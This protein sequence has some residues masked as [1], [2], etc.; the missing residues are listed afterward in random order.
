MIKTGM[1]PAS[2]ELEGWWDTLVVQTSKRVQWDSD[3]CL[4]P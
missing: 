2:L 1:V 4:D 3:K